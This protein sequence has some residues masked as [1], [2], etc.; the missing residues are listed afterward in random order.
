[1]RL[2]LAPRAQIDFDEILDYLTTFA[3]PAVAQ[4]YGREIQAAINRLADS[5][6]TGFPRPDLGLG[7]RAVIVYPY[8]IFYEEQADSREVVVLR[9]STGGARLPGSLL[10]P[11]RP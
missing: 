6:G 9:S 11:P 4:R 5:P 7:T 2:R 3:S 10:R 1:M 8:L